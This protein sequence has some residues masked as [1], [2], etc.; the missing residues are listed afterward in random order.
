MTVFSVAEPAA[1]I[2][3]GHTALGIE[4]GSTRI[5]ACLIDGTGHVLG[6]GTHTWAS[7]LVNGLWSYDLADVW[8]GVQAAFA[9]LAASVHD[10]YGARLR[11]VGSIGVSAMMHGYLARDA[12]GLLLTP[13][14]TW[15]N[16]NTAT[17]AAALSEALGVTIPLRWSV[18]HLYQAVLDGEK[19]IA[20]I[21]SI[22]TL[23]GYVHEMLTGRRV[24]G[25]G[26][27]SGMFPI[28]ASGD[29]YD[30]ALI[31]RTDRMLAAAGADLHLRDLLP[32]V[33]P[34]GADAGRLTAAGAALL[35]PSGML[36]PGI[37]LCPPEGDA[38]TGMVATG[39]VAP[40][41]GNVSVGTSI[42]AMIVLD[43][44]LPRQHPEVDLVTT[45][46]GTP[47]AMV[48]CNNGAAEIETWV[49]T[50][51]DFAAALGD[52]PSDDA[53]YAALFE[54]A[55][56]AA[57]D[58]GGIV[59]YHYLAGEPIAGLDVGRPLLTR[60]AGSG[61]DFAD[62]AR[63]LVY[64]VF[65]TLSLGM[66]ILADDGVVVERLFAHGGMFRAGDP[67]RQLMA[68]IMDIPVT[69]APTATEGGAW[70]MALLAMYAQE[71]DRRR[72]AT[73]VEDFVD[74]SPTAATGV[75]DAASAAGYRVF[76][77]QFRT[78]LPVVRSAVDTLGPLADA[79]PTKE[80]LA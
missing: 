64:G 32:T 44:P 72:F 60:P 49:R 6:T 58:A 35:D 33:L 55:A 47:V 40:R 4:W 18:A 57:P 80:I 79:S 71:P 43:Q 22:T 20:R 63:A 1:A 23:A 50:F 24:L 15:R 48:H 62:F 56:T 21:A 78:G 29:D 76:L 75:P 73:F 34:A 59:A 19:H 66:G 77:E 36:A 53:A 61:M 70:G 26:D 54:A 31:E 37:P 12:N 8:V 52:R 25:V 69:V 67:A 3:S 45:P 39:A 13:M 27:A 65:G 9:E 7:A 46:V 30:A 14:R 17:A 11:S 10:E 51:T 5:K 28:G 16:T 38:G 74:S 41:T 42:F 68:D 2:A